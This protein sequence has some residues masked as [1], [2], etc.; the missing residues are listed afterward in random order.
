MRF[1]LA[2][3]ILLAG[4]IIVAVLIAEFLVMI[5]SFRKTAQATDAQEAARRSATT[6]Q[7]IEKY[8]LD[9][10]TGSRGFIITGEPSFLQPWTTA[11]KELP[12]AS[13]RLLA[14]DPS[15]AAMAIDASWRYYLSAW[16]IPLV[17]LARRDP[18]KAR[19]RL[20]QQRAKDTFDEIR[21]L[22]DPYV[23][24]QNTEALHQQQRIDQA[25]DRGRK[26]V[27]AGIALTA[28]LFLM[29][30]AL[31][32]R[33]AV[34]PLRRMAEAANQ[35]AAGDLDAVVPEQGAGEVGLLARAFNQM[36][37]SLSQQQRS[38][39][40]QNLDLERLANVLR[41]VL[42]S[43]VD[44]ILLSDAEGN[45]QLANRPIVEMT[46]DLGMTFEGSVTER[47]LSVAHRMQD[48]DDFR[49]AMIYLGTNPDEPTFNEFEEVQSGRVFQG[50]TSV[51]RDE[52]G[53][54]IGR[55]WTMRDVT[56]QRELDRLKDDFVATVSHE[57]RTPLTSMMGFLQMIREGE[58]GDL[59]PEQDRF[60]SI[61]YRSSERL[62]RLV[63]DLLFVA[64][65][66]ASGI[67]LQPQDVRLDEVMQEAVESIAATARSRELALVEDIRDVP[68]IEADRERVSQLLGNLLSN[69]MKFTPSG[70]TVT[71]RTFR[72]NGHV[73]AEVQDTGIGIP[74][75]EQDRLF[76]R[77]FRSSTATAQAIPGTGLGLV[78][79]KAI[80]ES[81]GG[82]ITVRSTPGEGTCFR[83]ELPI[84]RIRTEEDEE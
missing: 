64:R 55:I 12:V 84:E 8:V 40:Q 73:V 2:T 10:E 25:E 78:I 70:G 19:N 58:A 20:T 6:A 76:Q 67:Q 17:Q 50:W 79:S 22:I 11:R 36:S 43:T 81:H 15:N 49:A 29:L 42:D 74:I 45:V 83:L 71:A 75:A 65:L 52:R 63:G 14:D 3:R 4:A 34:T 31:A 26:T 38:L 80:A 27:G 37:R 46:R 47:L 13:A 9:L 32:L 48:P 18:P 57:L 5:G 66:D 39:A 53:E 60:L 44:G 77:F 16:S 30:V 51:V 61:V 7:Q 1:G 33:S 21:R 41:A 69:A 24:R 28:L 62:Q 82:T 72:E 59:T 23:S 35:I 54:F 68:P 56:R